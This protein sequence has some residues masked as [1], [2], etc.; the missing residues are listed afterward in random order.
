VSGP[1]AIDKIK[2]GALYDIIFMDH[3][4]PIMDGMEAVKIIRGMG[5]SAPIIA[6]TAN[7]VVGQADIFLANGFDDFISKPIDMRVLDVSLNEYIYGKQPPEA[8]AAA[9]AAA[10]A[11]VEKEQAEAQAMSA[12]GDGPGSQQALP[13]DVPGL[14]TG[15]GL[16]IFDGDPDTYLS[17]LRSFTKNVPEMLDK[18]RIVTEENLPEYAITVHA[19]KSISGWI[20]ADGIQAKAADLEA[21]AKEGD[22]AGVT[23]LNGALLGETENFINELRGQLEEVVSN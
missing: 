17:A 4:M 9:E 1:E 12:V 6:L 20:F 14:N 11:A 8:L 2:S 13:F 18:L 7:A 15:R 23:T 10:R 16:A 21:L 22:F 5:Y 19:L 3:M